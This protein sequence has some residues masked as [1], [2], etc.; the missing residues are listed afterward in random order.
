MLAGR[1]RRGGLRLARDGAG[2]GR[3][4]GL[5]RR[6]GVPLTLGR[7]GA[8]LR[9]GPAG[10]TRLGLVRRVARRARRHRRPV[11]RVTARSASTSART[12]ASMA[13]ASIPATC[14]CSAGVAE[15]GIACAASLVTRGGW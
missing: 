7:A 2:L 8:R 11:H 9:P 14:N 12:A 10:R 3:C 5:E 4:A 1:L 6:G 15:P 13:R